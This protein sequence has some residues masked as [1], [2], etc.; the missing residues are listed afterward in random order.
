MRLS[1]ALLALVLAATPVLARDRHSRDIWQVSRPDA[2]GALLVILLLGGGLAT[3][4]LLLRGPK[5]GAAPPDGPV[6]HDP[7]DRELAALS[8]ARGRL[9]QELA[10]EGQAIKAAVVPLIEGPLVELD[11]RVA[12]LAAAGRSA[13]PIGAGEQARSSE[14]LARIERALLEEDDPAARALLMAS[15]QE[16]LTADATRAALA[17]RARLV[18]LELARLRA[19]LEA[20]PARLREVAASQLAG[21]DAEAEWIAHGLLDAVRHS[22]QVLDDVAPN[23]RPDPARVR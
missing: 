18:A 13:A 19:A 10:R 2:G 16:L 12:S 14:E 15:R 23:A 17:R 3:A 20:L 9:E 4:A 21:G 7:I 8:A 11:K 6:G 5:R 22:S 1:P